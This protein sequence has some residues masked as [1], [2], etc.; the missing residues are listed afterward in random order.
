MIE[1]IY[2]PILTVINRPIDIPV[3]TIDEVIDNT[4]L[5]ID[6]DTWDD[7]EVWGEN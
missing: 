5:W 2:T 3:K 1:G 6:P 4:T 7:L